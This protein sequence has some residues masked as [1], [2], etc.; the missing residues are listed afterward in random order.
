MEAKV[1][2]V[3]G[4]QSGPEAASLNERIARV[5]E[6][7]KLLLHSHLKIAAARTRTTRLLNEHARP[8]AGHVHLKQR[9]GYRVTKCW[10][11]RRGFV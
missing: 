3:Q 7:T 9:G 10:S 5:L 6:Q 4:G 1:E 11:T 2:I 8:A